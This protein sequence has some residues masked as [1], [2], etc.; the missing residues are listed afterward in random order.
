MHGIS[1][2]SSRSGATPLSL[3]VR[4]SKLA[5][6]ILPSIL[7]PNW[8]DGGHFNLPMEALRPPAV[9]W[10][11]DSA[12]VGIGIWLQHDSCHG[13]LQMRLPMPIDEAEC[14]AR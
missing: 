3:S 6:G 12:R 13:Q 10:R 2:E 1:N 4:L 7:D 11:S 14:L 9:C 8:D 5:R